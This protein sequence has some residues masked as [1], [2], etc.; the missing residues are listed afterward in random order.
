MYHDDGK[1]RIRRRLKD[2]DILERDGYP[3]IGECTNYD[4]VEC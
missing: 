3:M 2:K 4:D 1:R